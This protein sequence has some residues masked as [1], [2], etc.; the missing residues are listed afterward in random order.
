MDAGI[1]G[2]RCV[3]LLAASLALARAGVVCAQ[4][5][6]NP[7]DSLELSPGSLIP[8][9][10]GRLDEHSWREA[11]RVPLIW[12]WFPHDDA[13]PPV[14]TLCL[15][16]AG[17]NA[18]YVGCRASDPEPGAIRAH[19]AERD[20]APGDDAIAVLL[21]PTGTRRRG[22]R[23]TVTALGV[24]TDA[25]YSEDGG[26][27][28]TWD[29]T[30]QSAGR[31]TQAGYVVELAIPYR[32]L[33][34]SRV[35]SAGP[36][37][38]TWRI[39]IERRWPR[40]SAF[41][42]ASIPLDR[43]NS[44]L[45]CQATSLSGL[46]DVPAGRGA[47]FQ[48]TIVGTRSVSDAE[49]DGRATTT[50]VSPG[51]S[52]RW[53]PTP[54]L[55]TAFALNPDFSQVE[56]DAAEFEVNRRF[57]LS[58]P[59][60]RPFFLD[61]AEF[62]DV[63]PELLLTRSVV[64]PIAGGKLTWQQNRQALGLL[65]TVD[66]VNSRII[67]GNEAS[68][69]VSTEAD[70]TG[71]VGRYRVDLAGASSVGAFAAARLA[72]AYHDVVVA[73]DGAFRLG[74]SH[75][76]R[77]L[78][79]G[80]HADDED[81]VESLTGR[82]GGFT[83][84]RWN[85][86]YDY[87]SRDW[88]VEAGVRGITAGFRSDAGVLQRVDL[89]GPELQITRTVRPEMS[90]WYD[91]IVFDVQVQRL[92]AFDGRVIDDKL[93]LA[94]HYAGPLQSGIE[95][96]HAWRHEASGG[97]LYPL[98]ET[99]L[100]LETRPSGWLSMSASARFGDEIDNDNNRLGHGLELGLTA[101]LLAGRSLRVALDHRLLRLSTDVDEIFHAWL[102]ESRIEYHFGLPFFARIVLQY[103]Q[104]ERNP[105]LWIDPV[106]ATSNGLFAQ[107]LLSYE[108]SPTTVLYA[109]YSA[110]TRDFVGLDLEPQRYSFFVKMGYGWQF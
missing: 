95:A 54:G 13:P 24:Q 93:G 71:L 23:F 103:R 68:E 21:D 1:I 18:L 59:E 92:T 8:R 6:P 16:W 28:E 84:A 63:S 52:G 47:W 40:G 58:F 42:L 73:A 50:D 20:P 86:R 26:D 57:A 106:P 89:I 107:G 85:A 44:C 51:A 11:A 39:L 4:G 45:L 33:R 46:S 67:P 38:Q 75:R 110:T 64:D 7:P 30:W 61:D 12:Q 49:A 37:A 80:S 65:A 55:R 77:L 36:G 22:Y 81:T 76:L 25:L 99:E 100:Q 48:P 15:L 90:T 91:Q 19:F 31:I 60:K 109:G 3:R 79:A 17:R 104:I 10:D 83:G 66:R 41:R 29:A 43:G 94:L 34:R 27:D 53:S 32:A 101:R 96:S 62:F 69:R 78:L 72:P 70:V 88:E 2:S 98:H 35:S 9:I 102:S 105:A 97:R 82:N 14:E 56:A 87:D 5:A 74:R 108:P